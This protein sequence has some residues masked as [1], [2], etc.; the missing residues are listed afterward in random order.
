[1]L[2]NIVLIAVILQLMLVM[3][4][5]AG[6]PQLLVV[7]PGF[8][9]HSSRIPVLLNSLLVLNVTDISWNCIIFNYEEPA[10]RIERSKDPSTYLEAD[11]DAL[12]QL[13]EIHNYY[14]SNFG[15]YLKAIS[16]SLLYWGE[17]SHVF[18]LLDDVSLTENFNLSSF[19]NIMTRNNLSVA[20][21][22]INN[23]Y[24]SILRKRNFGSRTQECAVGFEVESMEP[25]A[26]ALTLQGWECLWDLLDPQINPGGFGYFSVYYHYCKQFIPGLKMGVIRSMLA[27]HNKD[28]L[29]NLASSQLSQPP[30]GVC[31]YP[32]RGT[33]F[34]NY[35]KAL[36]ERRN[37]TAISGK[38]HWCGPGLL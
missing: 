35:L 9:F 34:K 30:E 8:G 31:S 16:P 2:G 3:S 13:C 24:I 5:S 1:M 10:T 37:Y 23:A 20:S 25:F 4:N 29:P 38:P 32:G 26:T 28:R 18:L 6:A 7:V 27:V 36:A 14:Y 15:I 21:P 33:Q 19:I 17:F 12:A 11:R 22:S